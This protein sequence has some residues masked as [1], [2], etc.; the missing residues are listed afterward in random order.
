MNFQVPPVSLHWSH[1]ANASWFMRYLWK[2]LEQDEHW[3]RLGWCDRDVSL[4]SG[5]QQRLLTF[6]KK[7]KVVELIESQ[8]GL[9]WKRPQETYSSNLLVWAGT[10]S[11]GPR[12]SRPCRTLLWTLVGM[13]TWT[14]LWA[15]CAN[16]SPLSQ[17]RIIL[18][19]AK[20]MDWGALFW[21]FIQKTLNFAVC[22]QCLCF[23]LCAYL[24]G[25]VMFLS[26]QVY[27][28]NQVWAVGNQPSVK[29]CW[30][31]LWFQKTVVQIHK[32]LRSKEMDFEKYFWGILE[33]QYKFRPFSE[34]LQSLY[35]PIS[36]TWVLRSY[37]F[38]KKSAMIS[39]FAN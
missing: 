27:R 28:L 10:P 26:V 12:C 39:C 13:N 23:G 32:Y 21:C 19:C 34:G 9:C 16:V 37:N 25:Q 35:S 29:L 7:T 38:I 31:S 11:T 20:C 36:W 33:L 6:F 15:A 18:S 3:V 17:F 1:C 8:S 24:L 14:L 30:L 22:P 4:N 5:D 2:G